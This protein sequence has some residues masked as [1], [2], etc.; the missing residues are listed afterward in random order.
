[1]TEYANQPD[2]SFPLF[3]PGS[4][5]ERIAKAW[6][7]GTDAII[8]D[9]EDAV[10]AADKQSARSAVSGAITERPTVTTY[11]RINGVETPWYDQ[12]L[13][14][15]TGVPFHGVLLPKAETADQ[16]AALRRRLQPGQKIIALIE[17]ARGVANVRAIAPEADRLAF[18]S[19]DYCA[20]MGLEH[21]QTALLHA[22]SEIVLAARIAGIGGPLDGITTATDDAAVIQQDAA[23][24]AELGFAGK[25][26]IHPAQL[27]P[28]RQGF[29]P[30]SDEIVWAEQVID[31]VTDSGAARVNGQMV[32]APVI[33]RARALLA[34]QAA[35]S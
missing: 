13:E 2:F 19:I 34:R 27:L 20:D 1:M 9:L 18:G 25:L 12:D 32:D 29:A 35:L 4:R 7:A 16:L 22:R 10:A 30:S 24:S 6:V 11:L 31:A 3:V 14:L 23:H 26:L 5:P 33:T 8:V 28:A 17:T 21:T 15:L